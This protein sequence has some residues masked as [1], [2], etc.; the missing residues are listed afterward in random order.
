MR[1]KPVTGLLISSLFAQ[2]VTRQSP[3]TGWEDRPM[4]QV[5]LL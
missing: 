5:A 4:G 1:L 3:E 2:R